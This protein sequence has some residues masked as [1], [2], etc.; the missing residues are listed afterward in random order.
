ME[1][2][3]NNVYPRPQLKRDSFFSLNGEWLLDETKIIVPFPPE[4]QLSHYNKP[5]NEHMTYE[6]V[7]SSGGIFTI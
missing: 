1:M 6:K 5:I 2:T 4:S 3:W 7:F